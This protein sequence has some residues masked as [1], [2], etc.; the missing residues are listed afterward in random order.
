MKGTD[1]NRRCDY[2]GKPKHTRETCWKLHGRPTR[3]GGGKRL[4]SSR[5]QAYMSGQADD[6]LNKENSGHSS[7]SHDE[8]KTL[9][10]L[11]TRLEFPS[12]SN[13]PSAFIPSSNIAQTGI[14]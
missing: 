5:P 6:G 10:S 8:V 11:L 14:P 12:L 4:V 13:A 7:L 2:C 1:D 9:R 3:G